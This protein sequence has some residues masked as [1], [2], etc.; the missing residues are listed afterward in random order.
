MVPEWGV[1]LPGD[2]A[3]IPLNWEL[4]LHPGNFVSL[5]PLSQQAKKGITVLRGVVDPDY[6]E[7]IG[8][9]L[10]NGGKKDYVWNAEDP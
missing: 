7:D 5:M 6:H 9:L 10:H 1:F 2:T 4:R 8:L 3:N